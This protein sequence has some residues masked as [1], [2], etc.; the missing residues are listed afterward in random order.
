MA[1]DPTRHQ[2]EGITKAGVRCVRQ[3]PTSHQRCPTHSQTQPESSAAVTNSEA[4]RA[5]ALSW[6]R[7]GLTYHE[8]GLRLEI[9]RQAAQQLVQR[10]LADLASDPLEVAHLRELARGRLEQLLVPVFP[11]AANIASPDYVATELALKIIDRLVKLDGLN[12]PVRHEHSGADGGPIQVREVTAEL[13]RGV[14]AELARRS[15]MMDRA[16]EA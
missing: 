16:I 1:P 8:I 4:T 13:M 15:Q 12:A 9:T 6:R 5:S 11:R 10:A 7:V 14:G 2:C 3:I